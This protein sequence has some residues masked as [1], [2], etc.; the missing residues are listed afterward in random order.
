LRLRLERLRNN[1]FNLVIADLA[2]GA[3]SRLVIKPIQAMLYEALA[4]GPSRLTTTVL[5]SCEISC[6]VLLG[7]LI[8]KQCGK[9]LGWC[10]QRQR[11][12]MDE[13]VPWSTSE[14]WARA[15]MS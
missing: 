8:G 2:R 6:A 9:P 14:T 1:V 11:A 13:T 7:H 3:A 4:L 10:P 12:N 15:A 5:S